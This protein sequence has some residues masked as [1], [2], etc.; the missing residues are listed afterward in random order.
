MSQRLF[1]QVRKCVVSD[2]SKHSTPALFH[3]WTEE[4][5]NIQALVEGRSG[6]TYFVPRSWVRFVDTKE[7]MYKKTVEGI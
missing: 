6:N 1:N 4:N 3:F 2:L 7:L 5:G